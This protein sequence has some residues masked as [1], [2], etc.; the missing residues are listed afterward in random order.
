[1]GCFA[2]QRLRVWWN[3]S[4]LPQVC[5]GRA[6]SGGGD[7]QVGQL[8]LEG[9]AAMT[10]RGG[11][12]RAVVGQHRGGEPVDGGGLVEAGHDVGGLGDRPGVAGDQEPGIVVLQVEDLD[13]ATS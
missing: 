5:D 2:S 6:G 1:M 11:E 12:D 9:A 8:Q 7:S 4:T 3:R 10:G 13:L